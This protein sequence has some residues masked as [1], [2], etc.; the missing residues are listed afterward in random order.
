MIN[1][2]RISRVLPPVQ[3]R[4]LAVS[5][6]LGDAVEAG[7]P[8]VTLTSP[9]ADAAISASLQAEATLRQAKVTVSKTDTDLERAR[10]LLQ[11]QAISEKD[12][13]AAQND[14]ATARAALET[15]VAA[16]EQ[17]LRKL[18]LLGLTPSD[19]QQPVVVRAPFTGVITDISVTPGDY[20]AA[21]SS[22]AD[23]T[24]P[25][26][27][28]ADLSTVWVA[29]DVPA[30][31]MRL[32]V[33][34]LRKEGFVV[35]HAMSSEDGEDKA[36]VHDYDLIVLDPARKTTI[37]RPHA[38][39]PLLA[40][41]TGLLRHSRPSRLETMSVADLTLDPANRRV[42]RAGVRITLTPKQ[43][44]ILETLMRS[45]GEVVSRTRLAEQVW[46]DASM[47]FDN[48]VEAH[49]SHLRRK[50]E[51]GRDT[52]LIHTIRGTGYRLGPERP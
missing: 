47:V 11:Y 39:K 10:K 42:T 1:P 49:V 4:V 7:Q 19:L 20:R 40:R 38:F 12:V 3:G 50:L 45:A 36:T 30:P 46:D 2:N 32:M 43:Y 48:L 29:S 44:A 22:A 41:I 23:V 5:V 33:T 24:T 17:A 34:G 21:V 28:V 35:D 8:L 15:A 25:L 6:K 37:G 18:T 31:F 9:D 51:R 52:P 27:S 16:R 13:L 26:M 14:A